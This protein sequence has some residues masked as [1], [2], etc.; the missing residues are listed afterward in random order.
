MNQIVLYVQTVL[1]YVCSIYHLDNHH[2]SLYEEES[3][4]NLNIFF[5]NR[6]CTNRIENTSSLLNIVPTTFSAGVPVLH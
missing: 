3:K 6:I 1:Y 5:T 2:G 4:C